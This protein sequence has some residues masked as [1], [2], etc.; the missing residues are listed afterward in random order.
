MRGGKIRDSSRAQKLRGVEGK[1]PGRANS[2]HTTGFG[3]E[4]QI[5][6]AQCRVKS[7]RLFATIGDTFTE[8]AKLAGWLGKIHTTAAG[9]GREISFCAGAGGGIVGGVG[10]LVPQQ[11]M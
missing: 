11:A 1:N 6:K 9:A 4:D 7:G 2:R 5:R 10:A 3:W 8:A